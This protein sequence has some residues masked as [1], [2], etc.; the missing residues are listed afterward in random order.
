MPEPLRAQVNVPF[1]ADAIPQFAGGL[2]GGL[3]GSI[4]AGVYDAPYPGGNMVVAPSTGGIIQIGPDDDASYRA[5]ITVPVPV[6]D[7]VVRWI[8]PAQG[9]Q[10]EQIA[11]EPLVVSATDPN[12]VPAVLTITTSAKGSIYVGDAITASA[13]WT[14]GGIPTDPDSVTLSYQGGL[15][16]PA[17]LTYGVDAQ[18]TRAAVGAYGATIVALSAGI[19]EIQWTGTGAA[20]KTG[21]V[22]LVVQPRPV[23]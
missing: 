16:Q 5:T 3:V 17:T 8:I 15:G 22:K 23:L 20:S 19:F 12:A 7:G 6:P 2:P 4:T 18:I 10:P 13:N 21:V 11:E 9:L 1:T 14:V